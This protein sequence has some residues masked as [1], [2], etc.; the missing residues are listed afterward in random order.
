MQLFSTQAYADI[1]FSAD[2]VQLICPS[3]D[4]LSRCV[5]LDEL[6][7]QQ[8]MQAKDQIFEHFLHSQRLAPPRGMPFSMSRMTLR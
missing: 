7:P 6:P 4:V 5:A 8:R 2:S 1:D 3:A